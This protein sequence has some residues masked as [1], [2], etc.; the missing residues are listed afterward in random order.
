M[1]VNPGAPNAQ[2]FE[3]M[4]QAHAERK[5]E[6][7][8]PAKASGFSLASTPQS[9]GGPQQ[10]AQ[11]SPAQP[12]SPIEQTALKV[13]QRVLEGKMTQPAEAR[14]EVIASI[15]QTKYEHLIEPSRRPQALSAIEYTLSEDP[16]L[17]REVDQLLIHA[18]RELASS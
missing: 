11:A 1:K 16:R 14:R 12:A 7:A 5:Q 6:M 2:L 13:A 18:A 4:R 10:A 9:V 15:V 3:L 8:G 17:A